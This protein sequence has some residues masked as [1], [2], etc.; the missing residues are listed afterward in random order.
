[1]KIIGGLGAR[2]EEHAV[3][4]HLLINGK[5]HAMPRLLLLGKE[6]VVLRLLL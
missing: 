6:Q 2:L 1:M 3:L 5:H 4:W